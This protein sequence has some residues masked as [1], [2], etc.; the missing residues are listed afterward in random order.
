MLSQISRKHDFCSRRHKLKGE[1]AT[2]T[3]KKGKFL[4]NTEKIRCAASVEKFPVVRTLAGILKDGMIS[5]MSI[6]APT[7]LY[8][9]ETSSKNKLCGLQR[10]STDIKTLKTL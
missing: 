10:K 4:Q 6:A 2:K 5:L 1:N 9:K 8:R 3:A 7:I